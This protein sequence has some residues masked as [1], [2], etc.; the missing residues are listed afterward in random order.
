MIRVE[1]LVKRYGD[2]C[3]VDH[4]SFEVKEGEILGFLGP[5]GAGKSTT[6]NMITGYISATEGEVYIDGHNVYEEPEAAKRQIGYLPEIPPVYPDMR[7]KEYLMFAAELKGLKGALRK[8]E[9]ARVMEA[10]NITHMQGRLIKHLSKGYRQRT[11]VAQALLGNPKVIILDEPTVGLDPAQIIEM[12]EL[13]RDLAKQHTIIL[14]SHIL[15]EVNA[16]CDRVLI[17]NHGKKLVLDTPERVIGKLGGTDGVNL[18][19]KQESGAVRQL[20]STVG[21]IERIEEVSQP[22]DREGFSRFHVYPR[23]E[24]ALPEVLFYTFANAG[25]P[26]YEMNSIQRSLEEVFIA[27]TKEEN[28]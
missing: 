6:M 27:M 9:V 13:I 20:L 4:L 16:I 1:N 15:F 26:I 18:Y 8:S 25:I 5:N 10:A 17:I 22:G 19:V 11:G 7:V 2:F 24:V 28:A 3:A 21:V 23:V 14:S 12:R